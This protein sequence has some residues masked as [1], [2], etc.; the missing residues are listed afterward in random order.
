MSVL[1][2]SPAEPIV[3]LEPANGNDSD[4][5]SVG[6]ERLIAY[7]FSG[8]AALSVVFVV[9]ASNRGIDLSDQALYLAMIDD[10]VAAIRSASGF[11]ILLKPL[12]D[13]VDQSIVSFR[14]LRAGLDIGADVILGIALVRFMRNRHPGS[15]IDRPLG[16]LGAVALIVCG[17]FTMWAWAPNGFGYNEVGSILLTTMTAL[18]LLI[19]SKPSSMSLS[20]QV[21]SFVFGLFLAGMLITRWTATLGFV[22]CAAFVLFSNRPRGQALQLIG[23][24]IAG[25]IVALGAIHFLLLDLA[26]IAAGIWAGTTDVAQGAHAGDQILT[27]YLNSLIRGLRV[28]SA[29]LV[30]VLVIFAATHYHRLGKLS[31]RAAVATFPITVVLGLV[32]ERSYVNGRLNALNRWGTFLGLLCLGMLITAVR[33]RIGESGFRVAAG[34]SSL[35]LLLV[36]TP[37]LAAAGSDNPIFVNAVLVSPVWIAG[38][39]LLLR[40]ITPA[41]TPG[42]LGGI[43]LLV[44][45]ATVPYFAYDGLLVSPNRILGEQNI[46]VTEGRYEGLHVD[47]TTHQFFADLEEL[48]NAL[49][50]EP[51]VLSFWIRPAALYG[52]EGRGI[53]FPWYTPVD[54]GASAATI[55]G[56]CLE[57]GASPT[58]QVVIVTQEPDPRNWGPIQDALMTCGIN[59]PNDFEARKTLVASGDVELEVFVRDAPR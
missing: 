39:L 13:L 31:A 12:F 49:D 20:V 18:V 30:S 16:A 44:L 4:V 55:E 6:I 46:A 56:A 7:V 42:R 19:V 29:F 54:F 43:A 37:I 48:R 32:F 21:M 26:V 35:A 57:D 23:F 47:A 36:A 50:P 52:L 3:D 11:H 2:S 22:A 38:A 45:V 40:E 15:S 59:F 53:G 34:E 5:L 33:E 1:D 41:S 17:G 24:A 58:G 10:P 9:M 25:M 28:S 27:T 51:T 14:L 8:L